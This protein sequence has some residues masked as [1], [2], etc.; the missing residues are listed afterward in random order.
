MLGIDLNCPITYFN[1]SLR[2]F[3]KEERHITR[4]CS[5]DVLLLVFDGIMRFSEDGVPVEV[6]AGEY[7]IQR[8]NLYQTGDAVS[9]YP[10]YLYVHFDAA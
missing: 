1:A 10:K 5:C 9:D 8:K 4:L 6:R 2:F 3:K 7:Y